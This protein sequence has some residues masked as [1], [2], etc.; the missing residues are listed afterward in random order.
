MDKERKRFFEMESAPSQDAVK[1]VEMMAKYLEYYINMVCKA[2]TEFQTVD[3][4]FERR[5][6]VGIKLSNSK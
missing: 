1:I 4:N 5:S 3:F 6:T 2:V